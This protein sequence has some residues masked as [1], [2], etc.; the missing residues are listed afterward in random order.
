[1]AEV[2]DILEQKCHKAFTLHNELTLIAFLKKSMIRP[3][4]LKLDLN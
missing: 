2:H 4:I 3:R 1:M